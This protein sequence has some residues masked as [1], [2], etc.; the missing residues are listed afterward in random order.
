MILYETP[1][2]IELIDNLIFVNGTQHPRDVR[3]LAQMKDVVMGNASGNEDQYYMF[4]DIYKNNKI[5][6]D[7][8][9][10]PAGNIGDECPKT[11][12]HYHPKSPGGPGY[13][14]IYQVL[15]GSAIY[16]L[17]KM[18]SNETADVMIVDAKKGDVVLIPPDYGHVTINNGEEDLVMAN[19]VYDGFSSSYGDFKSNRGAAYYYL[20]SHEIVQNT[21]YIINKNERIISKDLNSRYDFGAKDLLEELHSDPKKYEFLEKPGLL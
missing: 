2:K 1:I 5:R 11:Y 12:G 20:K 4:R 6:F 15:N 7:I 8:T 19:L 17:Q 10:I 14:E 9:V 18:N 3:K 13:P 16:L 21:N